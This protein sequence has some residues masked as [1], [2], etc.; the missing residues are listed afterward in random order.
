MAGSDHGRAFFY[1][2][3]DAGVYDVSIEAVVPHYR[4]QHDT[5][6]Q[7]LTDH[8][9]EQ[10]ADHVRGFTGTILDLGSGTGAESLRVLDAFPHAHVVAVDFCAP[11]HDILRRT[12]RARGLTARCTFVLADIVGPG[13][14]PA[15]LRRKLPEHDQS[16]GYSAVI[17]AF[18]LHHLDH[19]QKAAV[20]RRVHEVLRPG[21]IFLNADLFSF[22]SR[23]LARQALAF[24]LGWI[25]EHL[26]PSARTTGLD[27]IVQ[28][29]LLRQWLTHYRRY[30]RLEPIENPTPQSKRGRPG[31]AQLL[32][33]A[34]FSVVAVPYRFWQTGI[35]FAIKSDG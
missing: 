17:S 29:R 2:E 34:G 11:M 23:R 21:G 4:E 13:C 9:R 1:A 26:G 16:E 14:S 30:N 12:V 22:Q 6:F 18:T 19:E 7:L 15:R 35:L 20:A 33:D 31:Q 27:P 28:R 25:Q 8:L 3:A 5:L 24:D 32:T 10:W